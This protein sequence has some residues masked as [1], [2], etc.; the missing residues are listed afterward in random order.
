MDSDLPDH[1]LDYEHSVLLAAGFGTRGG[2]VSHGLQEGVS[3]RRLS[4]RILSLQAHPEYPNFR[5]LFLEG[6]EPAEERLVYV[7]LQGDVSLPF[8]LG[9]TISVHVAIELV[10]GHQ[11]AGVMI[12]DAQD[13]LLLAT[14]EQ[15][16]ALEVPGWSIEWGPPIEGAQ[17]DVP[18]VAGM[19]RVPHHLIVSF[20]DRHAWVR[21]GWRQ[22]EAGQATWLVAGHAVRYRS[23]DAEGKESAPEGRAADPHSCF[24]IL[25]LEDVAPEDVAPG[26]GTLSGVEVPPSPHQAEWEVSQA[27]TT[28]P[29]HASLRDLTQETRAC[30]D[31][32]APAAALVKVMALGLCPDGRVDLSPEGNESARWEFAF[33]DASADPARHV[34]VT[35]LSAAFPFSSPAVDPQAGNLDDV[36]PLD[37]TLETLPESEPLA[38]AFAQAGGTLSGALGDMLLIQRLEGADVV[39]VLDASGTLWQEPL[40]P[41]G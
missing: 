5:T 13:V 14:V 18:E 22:L 3:E 25:R 23:T 8:A 40:G 41:R 17:E 39:R 7:V 35:W 21:D 34:T 10:H 19:S 36:D 38:H 28:S 26:E 2:R 37:V 32:V 30:V 31:A 11:M 9:D 15:T 24:A 1:A 4:G 27:K 29:P 33:Y 16:S 6:S 12:H 20:A